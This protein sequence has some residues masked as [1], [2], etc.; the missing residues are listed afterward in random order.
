MSTGIREKRLRRRIRGLYSTDS[1][2]ADA[3]PDDEVTVASGRPGV[4]LG[5]HRGN[6]DEG[7]C[8]PACARAACSAIRHRL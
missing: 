2:F 6:R 7:I 1:Q 3:C 8:R 4:T 5:A